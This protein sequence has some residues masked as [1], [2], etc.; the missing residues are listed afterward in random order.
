MASTSLPRRSKAASYTIQWC[1]A[2]PA[3]ASLP[4]QYWPKTGGAEVDVILVR[5]LRHPMQPELAIGAMDEN[6]KG[7]L[8]ME[9][10][11]EFAGH[12]A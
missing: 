6:G 2:F 5:K 4:P 8:I 9:R 10:A 7:Y 1:L 11:R 3:A 12:H